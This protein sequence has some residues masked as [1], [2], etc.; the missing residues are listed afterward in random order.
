MEGGVDPQVGLKPQSGQQS[1]LELNIPLFQT[2]ILSQTETVQF[3]STFS[4]LMMTKPAYTKGP[5]TDHAP[6]T[7]P[8]FSRLAYAK[9]T[10]TEIPQP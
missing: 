8:D 5:S 10:S 9:P 6:Y 4:N 7:E 1:E 3:K 2:K